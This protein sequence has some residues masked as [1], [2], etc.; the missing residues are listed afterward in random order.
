M[1]LARHF[2]CFGVWWVG[3]A[4]FGVVLRAIHTSVTCVS[5]A[6]FSWLRRSIQTFNLMT[7]AALAGIFTPYSTQNAIQLAMQARFRTFAVATTRRGV[8]LHERE[9]SMQSDG[10]FQTDGW[11][12][13]L[14]Q[15]TRLWESVASAPENAGKLVLCSDNDI[16][17]LP[18]WA[19]ALT[20]AYLAAGNSLDLCFQREGGGDSFFDAFPY[21]SGFFLMNC[22]GRMAQFWRE[23]SRRTALERPF[24]GDQTVVNALLHRRQAD[25]GP[26]CAAASETGGLSIRHGH[27]PP[28]LVVGGPTPHEPA[29]LAAEVVLQTARAHHAT[30]SG[31]AQGKLHALEQFVDAWLSQRNETRQQHVLPPRSAFAS[32]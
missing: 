32:S 25:G 1:C 22:S 6:Q 14:T 10:S 4:C 20:E 8:T 11:Y 5:R 27:F 16:T 2:V 3:P 26:A 23:V 18:G 17:L 9:L 13:A 21:N 31:D 24:A 7:S 15:K 29:S 28:L 12:H 19:E 30:A